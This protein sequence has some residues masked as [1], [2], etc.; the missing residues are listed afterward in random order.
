MTMTALTARVSTD[1][2]PTI[3]TPLHAS[4]ASI[5]DQRAVDRLV[6]VHMMNDRE[7]RWVTSVMSFLLSLSIVKPS[8]ANPI[9]ASNFLDTIAL[10]ISPVG[11][12]N[13]KW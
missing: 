8:V 13:I 7:R 3:G 5:I 4:D 12:E 10:S 6:R 9:T 11:E 1:A 2:L